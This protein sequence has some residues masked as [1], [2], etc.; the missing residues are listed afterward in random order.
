VNIIKRKRKFEIRNS[1]LFILGSARVLR[2]TYGRLH[3]EDY[4]NNE[5]AI[6]VRAVEKLAAENK[7]LRIENEDLRGTIF[8]EKRKKKRDKPLN[9]YEESE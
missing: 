6:L 3:A 7:I 9:F 5:V 2:R 1:F 8:E 4:I